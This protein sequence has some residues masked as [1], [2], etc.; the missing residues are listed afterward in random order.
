MDA[1]PYHYDENNKMS[2]QQLRHYRMKLYKETTDI[3][4][5]FDSLVFHL[6]KTVKESYQVEDI[7]RLLKSHEKELEKPLRECA[8]ISDVFDNAAS[9]WSFYNYRMIKKLINELGTKGD[10]E[11][12]KKSEWKF[13]EYLKKRLIRV[14]PEDAFCNEEHSEECFAVVKDGSMSSF[15]LKELDDMKLEFNGILGRKFLR[16]LPIEDLPKLKV[17]DTASTNDDSEFHDRYKNIPNS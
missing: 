1:S 7:A 16:L 13:R 10:K 3:K 5:S 15:T 8:T 9:I 17:L 14:C 4:L 2:E 6:Q 11:N 12:L